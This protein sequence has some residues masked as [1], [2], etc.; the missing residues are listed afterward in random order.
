MNRE[1]E[2]QTDLIELGTATVD[3]RGPA[4]IF[5]DEVLTTFAEG[6]SND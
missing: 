4:G 3:T 2:A 6:L 1:H 5:A